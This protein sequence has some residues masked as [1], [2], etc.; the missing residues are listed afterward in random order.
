MNLYLFPQFSDQVAVWAVN[1]LLHATLLSALALTATRLLKRDPVVR[2]WLLSLT[3]LAVVA[4]PVTGLFL[5][6]APLGLLSWSQSNGN[7][8]VAQATALDLTASAEH[9]SPNRVTPAAPLHGSSEVSTAS[10]T[11]EAPE[12]SAEPSRGQLVAGASARQTGIVA[13]GIGIAARATVDGTPARG[14][15]K[16]AVLV[17]T[18]VWLT[19]ALIFWIRFVRGWLA[20]ARLL[21][22][23]ETAGDVRLTALMP[24]VAHR[25]GVAKL[26]PIAISKEVTIPIAAGIRRPQVL[27]PAGL[28]DRV[29][30]QQ[31]SDILAHESAH[32]IGRDPALAVIQRMAAVIYWFHPLVYI[33]NRSLSH[34]CEE[35]CDNHVLKST[36]TTS[37]TRT[38]LSLAEQID[39]REPSLLTVGMLTAHSGLEHRIA[40]LLDVRRNRATR[41]TRRGMAQLSICCLGLALAALFGSVRW[42]GA[43]DPTRQESTKEAGTAGD[44]SETPP[45]IRVQSPEVEVAGQAVDPSGA[46]MPGVRVLALT[47]PEPME[48][49]AD[50]QGRF[51]L[52]V[53]RL[54]LEGLVLRGTSSDGQREA[55]HQIP[56]SPGRAETQQIQLVM[57]PPR[58]V[59][60]RVVDTQDRPIRGAYTAA[61][62]QYRA[63]DDGETDRQGRSVLHVPSNAPLQYAV[64]C[65]K[66]RGLDYRVYANAIN[67]T[68]EPFQLAQNHQEPITLVLNGTREVT[69]TALDQRG[70]PLAGVKVHP[71][72]FH[73]PDRGGH[74]NTG[75]AVFRDVTDEQGVARFSIPVDNDRTLDF[76]AVME[77]YC[78]ERRAWV[79]DSGVTNIVAQLVP[80]VPVTGRVALP[81]GGGAAGIEVMLVGVGY[82]SGGFAKTVRTDDDGNYRAEVFPDH[83]YQVVPHAAE[84]SAPPR[85][86]V[87]RDKP[88][89]N[90]DFTVRDSI[91][92]YGRVTVADDT[93]PLAGQRVELAL[94]NDKFYASLPE[95]EQLPNPAGNRKVVAPNIWWSTL[96]DDDGWFLFNVGPG[97]YSLRGPA[98]A[99]RVTFRLTDQRTYK[100]NLHA[101][102]PDTVPLRG[103]VVLLDDPQQGVAAAR[104]DGL[105]TAFRFRSF[106]TVSGEDGRFFVMRSRS[107]MKLRAISHDRRLGGVVQITED[108]PSINIPLS[109]T[110]TVRGRIVDDVTGQ[111]I[112]KR[113]VGSWW[114]YEPGSARSDSVSVTTDEDGRFTLTG[115]VPGQRYGLRVAQEPKPDSRALSWYTLREFIAD[116]QN[117]DLVEIRLNPE[118][119]PLDGLRR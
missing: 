69:V 5:P 29:S 65:Q 99:E 68:D 55:Y 44:S 40:Q 107:P 80:L 56:E 97:E 11:S 22:G 28:V 115:L 109:P 18:L 85:L 30:A 67:R 66:G 78:N 24:L 79:P 37:Y 60:I 3:L 43:Q 64:A 13:G 47:R 25:L 111:P 90:V 31:L 42:A 92:V 118:Q 62:V 54:Q 84:W 105:A 45:N 117:S 103:R 76:F 6:L 104:I 87:V 73:K 16:R 49:R 98:G 52:T 108:A 23:C 100:V 93:V 101:D 106:Q 70:A 4:S 17:V 39:M 7:C 48:T 88:V 119:V 20:L 1:S 21:H 83:C 36:N 89:D 26:P 114:Y 82:E 57:Q 94:V 71:W 72:R 113:R 50:A 41:L 38:L 77:G 74:L 19:G 12:L 32:A 34:A 33:L 51:R 59:V 46:A 27:L 63:F 110:A 102:L 91:Q 81:S 61:V 14:W 75:L 2:R 116:R 58:E 15:M 10:T 9:L 95:A 8:A 112:A 96:T 53:D 35:V 86:F